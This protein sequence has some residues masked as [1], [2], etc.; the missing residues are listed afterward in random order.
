ML[1]CITRDD[2]YTEEA[3]VVEE[4]NNKKKPK[5]YILT[6]SSMLFV[7]SLYQIL[8]LITIV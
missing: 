3:N 6:C 5:R 1:C 7:L 8:I 4:N 2:V